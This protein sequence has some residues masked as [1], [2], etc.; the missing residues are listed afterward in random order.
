[1]NIIDEEKEMKRKKRNRMI[2]IDD[3]TFFA[4]KAYSVD[5]KSISNFLSYLVGIYQRDKIR[6]DNAT[7][8]AG[9]E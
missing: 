1:M 5:F 7:N 3:M 9:L 6:L 2:Y 8:A 4:I